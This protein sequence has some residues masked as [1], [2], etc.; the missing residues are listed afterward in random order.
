M[1]DV[2][3][4]KSSIRAMKMQEMERNQASIRELVGQVQ[5]QEKGKPTFC[6]FYFKLALTARIGSGQAITG[7]TRQQFEKFI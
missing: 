4:T 6:L 2:S 1:S 7:V 5:A 3:D